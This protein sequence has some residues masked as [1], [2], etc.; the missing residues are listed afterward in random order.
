[1]LITKQNTKEKI[2]NNQNKSAY[3]PIYKSHQKLPIT[4]IKNLI[5]ICYNKTSIYKGGYKQL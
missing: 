4:Y 3:F 5:N 2:K 1:M